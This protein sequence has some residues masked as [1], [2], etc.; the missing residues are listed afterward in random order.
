MSGG[1]TQQSRRI[2]VNSLIAGG[3]LMVAVGIFVGLW[4][5]AAFF[6]LAVVGLIDLALA[7]A[8]ASGRIGLSG[9]SVVGASEP[10]ATGPD[11]AVQEATDDP[12]YN[13]YARE[14]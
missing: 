11:V 14:N 2:L 3:V 1:P 12:S 10:P 7:W 6:L 13:P 9:A 5:G 8:F 4:Q